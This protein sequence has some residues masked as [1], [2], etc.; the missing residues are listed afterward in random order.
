MN[1]KHSPAQ[2]LAILEHKDIVAILADASIPSE[3]CTTR[4]SESS[5][6]EPTS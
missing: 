1:G 2:H 5:G 3:C 6:Q 4:S